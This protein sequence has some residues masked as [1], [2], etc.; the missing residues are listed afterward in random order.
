ME[1]VAEMYLF[2]TD[3]ITNILK[4]RPSEYLLDQIS[5]I[6]QREQYVTTITIS[7]IVYG[8]MKS[9]R[10]EHHMRNLEEVLLPSVNI[11]GFDSK[12][13]Y[14]CGRLRAELEKIGRPL[15]LADLEIAAIAMAGEFTLITGNSKHFSRVEGLKMEN[16]INQ[17]GE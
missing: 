8:A 15:D 2:D 13:A 11:V 10:P 6:P 7:E 4:A 9:I 12:A 17:K 1:D 16:W 3:A 5:L 14:I